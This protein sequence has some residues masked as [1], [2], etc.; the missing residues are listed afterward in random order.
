[1]AQLMQD[2]GVVAAVDERRFVRH[3]DEVAIAV[4]RPS[5]IGLRKAIEGLVAAEVDFRPAL[6]DQFFGG[7][8][9][10]MHGL[11]Q[12]HGLELFRGAGR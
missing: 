2:R 4:I 9:V 6:V 3:L 12:F 5:A 7:F 8:V 11:R 10:G 1:M